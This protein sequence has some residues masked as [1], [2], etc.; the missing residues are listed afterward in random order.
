VEAI[1]RDSSLAILRRLTPRR[2]RWIVALFL[3]AVLALGSFGAY[4]WI[5][6]RRPPEVRPEILFP[7]N[8]AAA[9]KIVDSEGAFARHWAGR[10]SSNDD[11]AIEQ[12]LRA[13]GLWDVWLAEYGQR[14]ARSRI[15]AYKNAFFSLFGSECWVVF[16]EWAA[17]GLE[18][19]GE[20]A[21]LL[22]IRADS[23]L[24]ARIGPIANLWFPGHKV[25]KSEHR[26]VEIYEY[27]DAEDR[28]AI[29]LA[30]IGGWICASMRSV[31]REPVIRMIDQFYEAQRTGEASARLY[32]GG[33]EGFPSVINAD[34]YPKKLWAQLRQFAMKRGKPI[35]EESE[36]Q[37]LSWAQRLESIEEISLRQSGSSLLNLDLTLR[38]PRVENLQSVL[39]DT[40][41][42]PT[43]SAE[44]VT[45]STLQMHPPIIEA[46]FSYPFAIEGLPLFGIEWEKLVDDMKDLK[47]V[48]SRLADS[49][50]RIFEADSPPAD[51]RF[52]LAF[53]RSGQSAIPSVALW[54]DRA[55]VIF[56]RA[57]PADTWTSADP[58]V[59]KAHGDFAF[60]AGL[61]NGDSASTSTLNLAQNEH[62]LA[63]EVWAESS[64]P[65]IAFMLV[66][67]DE[68][69]PWMENFPI[70][71]LSSDDRGRW[72]KYR[73]YAHGLQLGIGSLAMRLDRRGEELVLKMRTLEFKAEP[74]AETGGS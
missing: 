27:I 20:V 36:S 18:G 62:R 74:Q 48:N 29:T 60:T 30:N 12:L 42:I 35:S 34:L 1:H 9:V 3:V 51:G 68:L 38:G 49:L 23:P 46:D 21:L 17:P 32:A 2:W 59:L 31:G 66:H 24:T 14:S 45:S 61:M 22:F 69:R 11:E 26:K 53:F 25:Q 58:G 15:R 10:G 44:R 41:K 72:M 16:G 70:I 52:G 8:I 64:A 28:R 7:N 67:F 65:P 33:A 56:G 50:E 39:I 5:R 6:A 63:S 43:I 19:T 47:W 54:E 4:E 37:I 71:L 40:R 13:V 73:A 57:S 55:P